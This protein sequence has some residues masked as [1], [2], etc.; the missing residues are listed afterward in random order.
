MTLL[1]KSVEDINALPNNSVKYS[2]FILLIKSLVD[3]IKMSNTPLLTLIKDY[4]KVVEIIRT[5]KNF[6]FDPQY[7]PISVLTGIDLTDMEKT[8]EVEDM[9]ITANILEAN[10]TFIPTE[11]PKVYT[12]NNGLS[13]AITSSTETLS[14]SVTN[15]TK[16]KNFNRKK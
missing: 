4:K 14:T 2:Q 5:I 10:K 15:N 7:K 16:N 3:D 8:K 11:A 9:I 6:V 13:T 1:Y 12:Y